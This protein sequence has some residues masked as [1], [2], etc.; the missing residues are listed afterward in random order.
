MPL[1]FSKKPALITYITCGDPDLATS[2]EI[3]LSAIDAGTNVVELGVP[4]SDPLADGPVIQRASERALQQGTS[5]QNVIDLAASVR[6]QRADAGLIVFSYLNPVV[7]YGM[8]R[9]AGAAS[10]AGIDGVLLTD[11]TVEESDEYRR[12]MRGHNLSTIFLAAPTSLDDRLKRI[13]DAS[14][15]FV[16]GV[17]RL[18]VTGTQTNLSSDAKDLV[19]RLRNVTSL[20]I[21]VGFGVSN[22]EQFRSVGEYADGVVIGSAIVSIIEREGKNA[23]VAVAEFIRSVKDQRSSASISGKS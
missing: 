11:M 19:S 1:D 3:I 14:S 7:R 8:K 21:A 2:R 23:P 6:K 13:A 15:G 5:L 18:G 17:S 10:D 16:Y 20:P 4:F 9:F 22:A 12:T